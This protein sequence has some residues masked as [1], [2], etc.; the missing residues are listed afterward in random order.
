MVLRSTC[1]GR[2]ALAALVALALLISAPVAAASTPREADQNSSPIGLLRQAMMAAIGSSGAVRAMDTPGNSLALLGARDRIE[3]G[4]AAGDEAGGSADRAAS[5]EPAQPPAEDEEV[6][7]ST[8][9]P[10]SAGTNGSHVPHA[11]S[12]RDVPIVANSRGEE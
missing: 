8:L 11:A 4:A 10:A 5:A 2:A 12:L 3:E 7:P 6:D 9:P 1:S